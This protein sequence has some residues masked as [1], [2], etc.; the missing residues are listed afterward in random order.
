MDS[1]RIKID[2]SSLPISINDIRDKYF[3]GDKL[4][5]VEKTALENFDAYR[6]AYLNAAENEEEFEKRYLELQAKANLEDFAF[7]AN[8]QNL[9]F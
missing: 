3:N 8:K 5:E 2:K 9:I 6:V 7:F 1:S 4:T